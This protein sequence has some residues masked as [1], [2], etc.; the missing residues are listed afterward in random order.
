M[1][2]DL[3]RIRAALEPLEADAAT[4]AWADRRPWHAATHVGIEDG[5]V[6]VDLD[7]LP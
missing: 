7:S 3:A 6:V 1:E 2:T 5:V 4:Q